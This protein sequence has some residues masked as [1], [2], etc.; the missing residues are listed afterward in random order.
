[1]FLFSYRT[2][3][4]DFSLAYFHSYEGKS[5]NELKKHFE[6]IKISE[7]IYGVYK[8]ALGLYSG[9]SADKEFTTI[10]IK[11]DKNK[12]ITE[13]RNLVVHAGH[14]PSKNEVEQ[15]GYSIYKYIIK[16]TK[17]SILR[18]MTLMTHTSMVCYNAVLFGFYH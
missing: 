3:R 1:M 10:K 8:L 6:A 4:V 17:H 9:D 5:V 11:V 2:F 15:V 7:R 13:L 14:I 12:K 18:N 16:Y